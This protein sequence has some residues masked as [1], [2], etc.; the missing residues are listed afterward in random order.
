MTGLLLFE[1]FSVNYL[2]LSANGSFYKW[3]IFYFLIYK[4][5]QKASV[6]S[7]YLDLSYSND[8]VLIAELRKVYFSN[9]LQR[10]FQL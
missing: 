9:I 4:T 7:H 10:S 6:R 1:H 2:T 8:N 3:Q 5:C